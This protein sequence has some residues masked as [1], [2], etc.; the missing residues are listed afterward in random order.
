MKLNGRKY[1]GDLDNNQLYIVNDTMTLSVDEKQ[2]D[3]SCDYVECH[4]KGKGESYFC[5]EYR[6][7]Q[8]PKNG[9]KAADI[10]YIRLD[11]KAYISIYDIKRSFN[12]DDEILHFIEQINTT[13]YDAKG[14]VCF[15][16]Y[17]DEQC[18]YKI[19]VITSDFDKEAIEKQ[20]DYYLDLNSKNKEM[21]QNSSTVLKKVASSK[22][23]S[24]NIRYKMLKAIADKKII[25]NDGKEY[26]LD[27]QIMHPVT[28][29]YKSC[30][31]FS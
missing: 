9:H 25:L 5:K 26:E 3:G 22:I 14:T 29:G 10:L 20:R 4:F 11:D 24:A 13:Y 23:I 31:L 16:K 2:E 28:N 12:N 17:D 27:V 15:A 6:P 19:G 7:S 21:M 1:T 30:I 18:Q 8:S